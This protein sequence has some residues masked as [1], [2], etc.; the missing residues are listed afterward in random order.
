MSFFEQW[1]TECQK[2]AKTLNESTN[3]QPVEAVN[4]LVAG[5]AKI[6]EKMLQQQARYLSSC[7]DELGQHYV[8]LT[9]KTDPV[10]A[11]EANYS[12]FCEQ[13]V[14][15]NSHYLNVLDLAGE[16]KTLVDQQVN[17]VFAR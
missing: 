17:K 9:K 16:A 4:E 10:A 11:V 6:A 1:V 12:F 2:T 14:K 8:A 3:W 5:K 13:Q 7:T 15:A